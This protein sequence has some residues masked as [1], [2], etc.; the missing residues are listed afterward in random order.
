M[1]IE[2]N[3]LLNYCLPSHRLEQCF[4]LIRETYFSLQKMAVIRRCTTGQMQKIHTCGVLSPHW[5]L[6]HTPYP[7]AQG[8]MQKR[9]QKDGK[10]QRTGWERLFIGCDRD[11]T[12][13]YS[14]WL[15]LPSK[16]QTFQYSRLEEGW[17]YE[18]SLCLRSH[19]P[20]KFAGGG[21]LSFLRDVSPDH[22]PCSSG[23]TFTHTHTD[24]TNWSQCI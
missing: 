6:D 18:A 5:D 24:I 16:G 7:K 15:W 2:S 14:Q 1:G 13:M 23:W 11:F 4:I 22:C 21:K 12:L 19:W 17:G 9:R 3:C 10:R 8:T 20:L